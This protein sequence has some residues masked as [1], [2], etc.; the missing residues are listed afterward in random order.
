MKKLI[1]V[2][3]IVLFVTGSANAALTWIFSP[4]SIQTAGSTTSVYQVNGNIEI[5]V[6]TNESDTQPLGIYGVSYALPMAENAT[7]WIITFD[8]HFKTWDSYNAAGTTGDQ[9]NGE[10][11]ANTG[12]WDSWSATITKGATY[13]DETLSDPI[14]TDPDIE[15]IFVLEGGTSY[16]DGFL[17]MYNLPWTSYV[18]VPATTGDQYYLNLVLDTSTPIAL[19][20]NYPSWGEW[21][22]VEV[23]V[24]PAP[25]AIL[26]GG[27]GVAL[28]GWMRRRKTL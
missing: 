13:W 6:P 25:G 10:P 11:I 18:Y 12:W 23:S 19:N 28:V 24:I 17:E 2:C 1:T 21:T 14:T 20:G 27:I 16:G 4:D 26:L 3:V 5:G 9:P 7:G 8:S 15:H 22:E